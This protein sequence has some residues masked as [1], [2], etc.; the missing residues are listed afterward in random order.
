MTS[1]PDETFVTCKTFRQC[2]SGA[3]TPGTVLLPFCCSFTPARRLVLPRPL[4]VASR[5]DRRSVGCN[6]SMVQVWSVRAVRAEVCRGRHAPSSRATS[7]RSRCRAPC[8]S[9]L[10]SS[11]DQKSSIFIDFHIG[12][13]RSGSRGQNTEI[14]FGSSQGHKS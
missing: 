8:R 3:P 9:T 12:K 1:A 7:A 6:V 11:R 2:G 13:L 5:S 4:W 14:W 10:W